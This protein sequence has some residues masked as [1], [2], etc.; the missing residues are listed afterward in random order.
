M[1]GRH[2][3]EYE[4]SHDSYENTADGVFNRRG[5]MTSH[6]DLTTNASLSW[7]TRA[8]VGWLEARIEAY[9]PHITILRLTGFVRDLFCILVLMGDP[10]LV[11]LRVTL[12]ST[13]LSSS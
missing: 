10:L 8:V 11:S 6:T 12:R 1:L 5:H 3:G 2:D 4:M 9:S 13:R 7:S